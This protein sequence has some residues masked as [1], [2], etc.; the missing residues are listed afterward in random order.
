MIVGND[1]ALKLEHQL[2]HSRGYKDTLQAV[3]EK[4]EK[5]FAVTKKIPKPH[6]K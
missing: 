6:A 1:F 2:P 3:K 4:S 5:M